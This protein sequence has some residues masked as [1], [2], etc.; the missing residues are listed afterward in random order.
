MYLDI[1]FLEENLIQ[2]NYTVLFFLAVQ[3]KHGYALSRGT[4]H[5]LSLIWICKADDISDQYTFS[6]IDSS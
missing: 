3:H 6:T 5:W 2:N 1:D 4:L